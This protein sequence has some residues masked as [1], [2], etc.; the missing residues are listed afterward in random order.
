[1]L[2]SSFASFLSLILNSFCFEPYF[3]ISVFEPVQFL[4]KTASAVPC[5]TYVLL[6]LS[7]LSALGAPK[8]PFESAGSWVTRLASYKMA[9]PLRAQSTWTTAILGHRAGLLQGDQGVVA[10]IRLK[11]VS[12]TQNIQPG[13]GVRAARPLPRRPKTAST[14]WRPSCTRSQLLG[15]GRGDPATTDHLG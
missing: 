3:P 4:Q 15:K 13:V 1:M 8:S 7:V 6:P 2:Q 14:C 11:L 9:C 10:S 12:L 5:K